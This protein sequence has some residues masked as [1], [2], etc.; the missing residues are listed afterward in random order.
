M[1][2]DLGCG[3]NP[4]EGFEGVD[5]YAFDG[6]VKHVLSLTALHLINEGAVNPDGSDAS[7]WARKPWPWSDSSVD[8]AYS[9]HFVEHLD[10]PERCWF[11]NELHRILKPGATA[12][13]I[14]PHWS[15][16]RAYGDPTHK[17]PAWSDMAAY[18]LRREW[19]LSQAPH[20]D[21][22][23]LPWGYSCDFEAIG[24]YSFRN[25]PDFTSKNDAYKQYA[26]QFYRDVIWD[27]VMTVKAIKPQAAET[28]MP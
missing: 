1:K 19:R 18:Y 16:G 28:P 4:R 14:V 20:T 24:A 9:S 13:I 15:S 23:L 21:V 10:Q 11:F 8:E 22:S 7:A 5:Q 25:D 3:P 6:K 27:F 2:L 17:W 26:M 12:Q